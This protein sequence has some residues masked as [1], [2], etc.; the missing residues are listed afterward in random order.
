MKS[1]EVQRKHYNKIAFEYINKRSNPTTL[2]YRNCLWTEFLRLIKFEIN[3]DENSLCLEA[4]CGACEGS[5]RLYK[6]FKKFRFEAFDYSEEMV[7]YAKHNKMC[8]DGI[9]V[10]KQLDILKFNKKRK[11]DCVIL[12]GGIHHVFKSAKKVINSINKSLK[13]GGIFINFEP[14]NNLWILSKIR[15][16]I[17]N[18]NSVFESSSEHDFKL[19][20]YNKMLFNS[21]FKII[22]Q[23]YPGLLGYVLFYNPDAF[24][25]LN[26]GGPKVSNLLCK[27][28]IFLGKTFIG[29]YFSFNTFTIARK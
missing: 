23:F 16:M 3:K 20:D 7:K 12:I 10:V 5:I 28:D 14:T 24:P 21:G 22:H 13:P 1:Q 2:A 19:C 8:K 15:E 4:M 11:Y 9:L 6:V 27:I 29:K 25:F 26:K 17:Y 18:R